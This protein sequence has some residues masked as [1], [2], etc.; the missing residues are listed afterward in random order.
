MSFFLFSF[1]GLLIAFRIFVFQFTAPLIKKKTLECYLARDN[2]REICRNS[3]SF[4]KDHLLWLKE[5][6]RS[7]SEHSFLK[8]KFRNEN[9][10]LPID[11]QII[12]VIAVTFLFLRTPLI[13]LVFYAI[14]Q[15]HCNMGEGQENYIDSLT[16]NQV[17]QRVSCLLPDKELGWPER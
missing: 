6:H 17:K 3:L 11:M 14:S 13:P 7:I 1:T 12:S 15:S 8:W 5:T 4:L 2:L 9:K 16:S 10:N